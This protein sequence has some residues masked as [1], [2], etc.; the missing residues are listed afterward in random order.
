[1]S[2]DFSKVSLG[3]AEF[4]SQLIHETFDAIL[5]AQSYQLEKYSELENALTLSNKLFRK[6][7]ISDAEFLGFQEENL[8]FSPQKNSALSENNIDVLRT[9]FNPDDFVQS[10]E[11]KR[12][13]DFGF[14][15]IDEYCTDKLIESKK[16]R[17]SALFNH[18]E[19][20]RLIVDSG[21]IKAKLELFCLNESA[22][23]VSKQAL[24]SQ[25]RT[26]VSPAIQ[27]TNFDVRELT[28]DK[29]HNIKVRELF[30]HE[31]SLKTLLID[32]N[33]LSKYDSSANRIPTTRLVANPIASSSTTN[34]FSEVTIKFKLI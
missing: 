21:E 27:K 13:T 7:Y 19:L 10:V 25:A 3:F 11:K 4:V 33:S 12:L 1:M 30:N 31:S 24:K 17:L 22:T 8:G 16:T 18:P 34:I 14:K 5:D 29:S 2:N 28:F 6:K 20:A 32:K 9:F 26:K 15:R 23:P